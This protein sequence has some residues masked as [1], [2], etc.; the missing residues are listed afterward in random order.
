M[1]VVI[2]QSNYIP[3]KGYFDAIAIADTFVLYDDMQ[4]TKRDW[5]NRNQIKTTNGLSWLSIPVEVK[6]KYFQKINET[7]ISDTN[8]NRN[9][10]NVLKHN[11]SK[12]KSYPE[13]KDF[14][15]ELYLSCNYQYLSEI[16]FHFLK[17]IAEF[18]EIDTAFKF[19]SAFEL[20]DGKT[21][22]LVNICKQL[23]AT[24]YYS[25]PA[26]KDYMD[27][28]LF[29]LENIS[30]HY[31]NHSGYKEYD[32]LFPPFCHAVSIL[33]LIFSEGMNAKLFLKK[34]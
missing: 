27:E 10:W 29:T 13:V 26:A 25:G 2:T 16:N 9:H 11:Y 4:Y 34:N 18:L 30:V 5:R 14:V 8:W 23:G 28:S 17:K 6:G 7:K 31:F 21:E 32:Q 19:S 24:D 20:L 12:S 3:W 15:E 1:N 22:K 33:D